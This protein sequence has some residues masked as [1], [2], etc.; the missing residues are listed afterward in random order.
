MKKDDDDDNDDG[1]WYYRQEDQDDD[2]RQTTGTDSMKGTKT[3][4]G[5]V[6]F[7]GRGT[8]IHSP[9]IYFSHQGNVPRCR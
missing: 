7:P 6:P 9:M 1:W 5:E 4:R 3:K 8:H 2:R